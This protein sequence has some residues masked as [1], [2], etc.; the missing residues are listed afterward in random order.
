MSSGFWQYP[1]GA[2]LDES[3]FIDS[4]TP[5]IMVALKYWHYTWE[6]AYNYTGGSHGISKNYQLEWEKDGQTL[7]DRMNACQ[8]EYEFIYV[9][10]N[11]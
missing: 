10:D 7:V 11:W 2:N 8:D 1:R 6:S 4:L 9:R 3:Q 5:E